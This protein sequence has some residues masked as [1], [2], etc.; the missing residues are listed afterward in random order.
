MV[1]SV[2]IQDDIEKSEVMGLFNDF[3]LVWLLVMLRYRHKKTSKR[4]FYC[5]FSQNYSILAGELSSG[6]ST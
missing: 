6:I 2:L 3:S 1:N 5:N 4:R